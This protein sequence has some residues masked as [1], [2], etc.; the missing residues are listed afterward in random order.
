MKDK[1]IYSL[2]VVAALGYFVDIYDLIVFNVVKNESLQAL[3]F[4]GEALKTNEI[5]LFNIQMT[6]ML[7]GGLLWGIW[8]DRKG[9]VSVLFGSI[10][11]YSA[12][13]IAN[14]FVGSIESYAVWRFIAG[15][16]LAGELGA[17]IT[18]VSETMHKEKR[19]YGTM[20]IVTFG[21]L[22]AVA[23]SL[24]GKTFGWQATYI[25]GGCMGLALLLL[26]AGAFESGM[27]NE[28]SKLS[29][30]SRGNF[31]MLF[32]QSNLLKRYLSCIAIGLPVWFVIGVLINLSARFGAVNQVQV[33]VAN[34]VMYA[35]LGLSVGDLLSGLLSQMLRSRRKVVFMYLIACFLLSLAYLF[36]PGKHTGYYHMM[37]FLLGAGTGYWA[38]FVTIAS[39]QFGTNIR[40]TVTNTVPNFVRGAVV[41]ITLGFKELSVM[42][43]VNIA[44]LIVGSICSV[45]AL[46]GTWYISETFNKDLN[47]YEQ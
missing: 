36:L 32:Q 16:G 38:L 43:D 12:A 9:R 34:C 23:A 31:F 39:E 24:V 27:Y 47:Y 37:S 20:I 42:Y 45:L 21:A 14:A 46:L 26:R 17:G 19:G 8:G 28:V 7:L 11:L 29:T 3:G 41:P 33:D 1:K 18:L 25:T 4:T 15:I 40:S 44:A 30:V 10:F 13:N 35:Y 6:G 2:I 22:G 5:F